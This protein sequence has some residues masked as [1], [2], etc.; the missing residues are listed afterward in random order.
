MK[1]GSRLAFLRGAMILNVDDEQHEIPLHFVLVSGFPGIAPKAFLSGEVDEDIIKNNPYVLKNMEIL[2]QYMNNW[3]GFHVSYN[4]NT[5]YY[6]IYQSFLLQPP[7]SSN[8]IIYPKEPEP[9]PAPPPKPNS[10]DRPF[11]GG[12][13]DED[14]DFKKALIMS[15]VQDKITTMNK[16]VGKLANAST[17]LNQHADEITALTDR[18]RTRKAILESEME[19][20]KTCSSQL[21]EK[22]ETIYSDKLW[23]DTANSNEKM[24]ANIDALVMP[25][26]DVSGYI[27]DYLSDE[28]ACEETMEI[29]KE[30]FRK[31]KISLDDY[32]ESV[33]SLANQQYMSMA[34]RRKIIS[35]LSANKR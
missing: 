28:K 24:V 1:S 14:K 2:N 18:E 12:I 5:M 19:Y 26:D 16:I 21:E 8:P 4:L 29:I 15:K 32:L 3:K 25:E 33:R 30:R 9:A 17:V 34:K 22:L 23:E 10:N 35:V 7:I 20:I 6:Y 13:G 11:N 27:L 31:K